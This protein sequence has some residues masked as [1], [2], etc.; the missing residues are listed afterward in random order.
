MNA[1]T[2]LNGVME[3]TIKIIYKFIK[4]EVQNQT[5]LNSAYKVV[6]LYRILFYKQFYI[7][8]KQGMLL[9]YCIISVFLGAKKLNLY[10]CQSTQKI[11]NK[12]Q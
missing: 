7:D 9:L 11:N 1:T 12:K 8:F 10:I 5:K 4:N 6:F 2:L 3:E